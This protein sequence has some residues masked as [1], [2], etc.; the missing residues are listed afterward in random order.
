[1][2]EQARTTD[3]GASRTSTAQASTR[4]AKARGLLPRLS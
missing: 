2:S 1:M 4:A 3:K